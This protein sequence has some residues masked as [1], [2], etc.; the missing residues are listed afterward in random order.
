MTSKRLRPEPRRSPWQS[1]ARDLARG[2]SAVPPY[3]AAG[4]EL[5]DRQWQA[6]AVDELAAQQIRSDVI[7]SAMDRVKRHTE[8][9]F[10][11]RLGDPQE[12]ALRQVA[13]WRRIGRP[14]L[15]LR[16]PHVGLLA[17]GSL[18]LAVV[19]T[20]CALGATVFASGGVVAL[21]VLVAVVTWAVCAPWSHQILDIATWRTMPLAAHLAATIA[22]AAT[23]LAVIGWFGTGGGSDQPLAAEHVWSAVTVAWA[24]YLVLAVANSRRWRTFG[25]LP[26]WLW[27]MQ[28]TLGLSTHVTGRHM[29]D[30][31]R[32]VAALV[33][34]PAT[35]SSLL[36]R[37]GPPED[38]VSLFKQ[39]VHKRIS[40]ADVRAVTQQRRQLWIWLVAAILTVV[41]SI[42]LLACFR[43]VP[44]QTF[45]AVFG[46]VGGLYRSV[47]VWRRL[48]TTLSDQGPPRA[49]AQP[50]PG[51][52][53]RPRP[54]ARS[55]AT[56]RQRDRR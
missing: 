2:W 40:D 19:L 9:N 13:R 25:S 44:E 18:R 52:G 43:Q 39:G 4:A 1:A 47:I 45:V 8:S 5:S 30:A 41:M 21:P 14:V 56:T 20:L 35:G 27:R 17:A 50:R 49:V 10:A 32:E 53:S 36:E 54:G 23:M 33:T 6:I 26:D 46:F 22:W 16:A 48:H 42:V 34:Q 55:R 31:R 24:G 7:D 11:S 37:F 29:S 3:P 15:A 38:V 12:W 51:V 28:C